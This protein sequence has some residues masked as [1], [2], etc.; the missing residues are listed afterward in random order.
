MKKLL[1]LPPN[2]VECFH[3]IQG[4][5]H[6]E[7]FCTHDPIGQKLGSGGGTAWLLQACKDAEAPEKDFSQWLGQ[8]KRILL[9]AGG[10]SRRL[11]SYAPSGKILT[12]IPVFRWKRGQ[13]LSQTLLDLQLPLY[14]QIMEKAPAHLHTLI[15][16]GDVYIRAT[17]RLQNIPDADVVCYGLWADSSLAQNHGVF[18]SSRKKPAELDFMLQKPSISEQN[19]LMQDYLYLMDIGIWLFSD[20]A[21]ELMMKRSMKMDGSLGFYDMYSEFGLALGNH[22]KIEDPELNSLKVVILPLPGGEFHHYGTSREMIS[23]TVTVQNSVTDQREIK[24]HH[25]KPCPA[26]FVQNADVRIKLTSQN[27]DLWVENSCIGKDWKIANRN[28]VTGVPEND[29]PLQLTSGLCIDVIPF[30]ETQY[31]ARPYGIDDK[32]KGALSDATVLYQGIPVEKWLKERGLTC[33]EIDGNQDLQAA[34]LFPVCDTVEELGL[35]IRWMT[36]EPGLKEGAEV[37]KKARKVSAD[38]ISAYANLHRFT[39]KGVRTYELAY[40][41]KKP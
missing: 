11:P 22:P 10:Q 31:V 2:L 29:W 8:E 27:S 16:S 14:E 18:V 34:C 36:T 35:A 33:S 41:G 40:S 6:E 39:A 15:A 7:W 28:I 26:M 4:V 9:H 19:A 20:R 3:D 37:W 12:P 5:S 38:D 32:F 25:A 24:L 30:G 23:S 17:G 13:K 21:I 1:S